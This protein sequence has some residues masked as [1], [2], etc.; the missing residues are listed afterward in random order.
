M[1]KHWKRCVMW[2]WQTIIKVH[3]ESKKTALID[4]T[5]LQ[6]IRILHAKADCP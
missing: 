6:E 4:Y 2:A 5:A 3:A 1:D